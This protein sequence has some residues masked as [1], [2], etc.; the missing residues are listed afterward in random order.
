MKP[1]KPFRTLHIHRRSKRHLSIRLPLHHTRIHPEM[2]QRDLHMQERRQTMR[3]AQMEQR[4]RIRAGAAEEERV[5][6][7]KEEEAGEFEEA[8]GHAGA[9]REMA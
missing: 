8:V 2:T 3:E 1:I 4:V 5:P 7:G 9:G 6:A